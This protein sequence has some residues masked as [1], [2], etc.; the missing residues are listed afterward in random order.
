MG[1]AGRLSYYVAGEGSPLLLIHSINAAGSVYEVKPIFEDQCRRR[2]VYAV[3]LPGFGMSDRS[4]RSYEVRLYVDAVHD[5][6]DL[7]E[8]ENGQVPID[9]LAVSLASEFLALAATERP[10]PPRTLALVTPTGF[11]R[12]VGM[13][14]KEP[15]Q[16]REI[17]GFYAFFTF[18]LWSQGIFDLLTSRVSIRYFLERTFGSKQIDEGMF[19]YDYLTTHQPGAKNAPLAF[20][21]GKLFTSGIRT[22]Y[23]KLEM[24]VWVPHGTRGDFKDFSGADWAKA[25][26]NWHFQPYDTGALPHF[27]RPVE[28]L[29]SYEAFLTAET[30]DAGVKARARRPDRPDRSD[31]A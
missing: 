17:P 14:A 16:S 10:R 3:D 20:V 29:Q 9:A 15:G 25:K 13:F 7:I 8:A 21:S 31:A 24:P 2:K 6:L 23:E 12:A 27:E 19:E 30:G 18:P 28:F 1:R 4:D 22:F 26:A 5:L 11:G